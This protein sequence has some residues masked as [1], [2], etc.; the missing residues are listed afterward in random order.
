MP[1]SKKS[2]NKQTKHKKSSNK[3][4]NKKSINKQNGGKNYIKKTPF[5]NSLIIYR[6]IKK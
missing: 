2:I 3:K 5:N 6:K 1:K 4:S